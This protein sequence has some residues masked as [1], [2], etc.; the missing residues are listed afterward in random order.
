MTTPSAAP[1]LAADIQAPDAWRILVLLLLAN[2]LN[3]FDRTLP[4]VVAESI[5]KEWGLSDFQLGSVSTAFV[6]V[7]AVAGLPLGRWADRGSRRLILALGLTLWSAFTGAAAF[8][9]SFLAYFVV[10]MCVGIGE[11]SF[12]PTANSLIGD[13]F[14]SARRARAIA[15]F[16]LGLPLGILLA[17]FAAGP[18]V[19][20]LGNWRA[21]FAV[22]ALP[23]LL[24]ALALLG[25][26]DPARG[27]ADAATAD[28]S[29]VAR[30]I[31]TLLA[32]PTFRW[33]I[34][35]GLTFN[36]A[37][38]A[39]TGFM[40]PLLQRHFLLPIGSAA[41]VSGVIVGVS[42]LVGLI[43]CGPV[44]DLLH[45][46]SEGARLRFCTL[47]LLT[48]S[49]ATAGALVLGRASIVLFTSLFALGVVSNYSYYVCVYPAVHDVV[50]PR[51]RGMAFAVYFAAMYL[52]GGAFGPAAVGALSDHLAAAAMRAAGSEVMTESA[53]AAGLYG[54]MALVPLIYGVTALFVAL[55]ARRFV[56]DARAMRSGS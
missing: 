53:R 10:R 23:G 38:Y 49:A 45:R 27:A 26:R 13:L 9:E 6:L 41:L 29:P 43:V 2:L 8:V 12:A 25:I 42:G 18:V 24:L 20:A 15:L 44:S 17:F 37:A 54:A 46:R 39:I 1:S 21:P 5:R 11:A 3:F 48:A 40:V 7:Y 30:P 55:A 51:L 33:I 35:S 32:I 4:A 28:A 31:R 47:A 50:A 52:L 19:Q 36:F 34:A 14:P 56:A 16:T 22:A